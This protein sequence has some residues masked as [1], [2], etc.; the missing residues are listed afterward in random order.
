MINMYL[1]FMCEVLTIFHDT[2][3][4]SA[5]NQ[6]GRWTAT[7]RSEWPS[8]NKKKLWNLKSYNSKLGV[9]LES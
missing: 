8:Y 6:M 5:S 2:Y 9:Q 3:L 4:N 1:C 7:S